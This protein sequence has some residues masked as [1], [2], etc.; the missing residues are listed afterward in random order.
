MKY[1]RI[2]VNDIDINNIITKLEL[3]KK[4]EF[5][6]YDLI[7]LNRNGASLTEDTLKIRVYQKNEWNSK[8]VLV[9]QK[10]V[11]LEKGAKKDKVLLKEEFDTEQEAKDFVK[12]H[13]SRQYEY[14]FSLEKDGIEYE[15]EHL[16]VWVENIKD[17][18]ISIEFGSLENK[19]I[20][21]A[22]AIFDVKERL[23]ESVPEYLYKKY[24]EMQR[25][26]NFKYR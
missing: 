10:T 14:K 20:E 4:S 25:S 8:N 19:Y 5:A 3:T 1:A 12:L 6:F 17:L 9:I 24:Y 26:I 18:G 15:N 13:F 23:S 16:K 22:I 21:K 7:Y 2:I 11:L